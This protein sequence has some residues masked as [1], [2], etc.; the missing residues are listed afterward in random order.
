MEG[1]FF[2]FLV[3]EVGLGE[4]ILIDL[5]KL[6]KLLFLIVVVMLGCFVFLLV[7]VML[8]C[9]VFLF[10]EC[11]FVVME[12]GFVFK[13]EI[14]EFYFVSFGGGR[15]SIGVIFCLIKRGNI[16]QLFYFLL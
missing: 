1:L 12:L 11:V 10:Q 14:E 5:N 9:F 13:F 3:C 8:V 2:N 7:V 15:F 16:I 6:V 4:E